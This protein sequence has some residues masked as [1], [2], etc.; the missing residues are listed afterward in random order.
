MA[1]GPEADVD[2]P[3]SMPFPP[4]ITVSDLPG[5]TAAGNRRL[6]WLSLLSSRPDRGRVSR[7]YGGRSLF[8]CFSTVAGA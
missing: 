6:T 1:D 4:L 3:P 8:M 2:D 7:L 5:S